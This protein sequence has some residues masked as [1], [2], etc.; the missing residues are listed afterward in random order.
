MEFKKQWISHFANNISNSFLQKKVLGQGQF[1][2]HI[3][4]F[5]KVDEKNFL[6]GD[7]A[8]NAFD[9]VNR[10]GAEYFNQDENRPSIHKLSKEMDSKYIDDFSEFYVVAEDWSWTYIK[11]HEEDCGPYFYKKEL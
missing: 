3:F 5:K 10:R 1:I 7:V 4:S 11:T 9:E 6:Q 8:R 2:W